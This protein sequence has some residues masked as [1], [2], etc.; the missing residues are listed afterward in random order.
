MAPRRI[1]ILAFPGLQSLDL[2]GPAEVFATADRLAGG[3]EYR[4]EIVGPSDGPLTTSSGI[5][6]V[7]HRSIARE[8]GPLDTLVVAGGLGM[9]RGLEYEPLIAWIRRAAGRAR[10]VA[11]VCNGSFLLARAGLLDGRRATTHWAWCDEL[12][13]RHPEIAV[14]DEP[15]FV[16][17]GSIYTSAGVTAGIDLSL[18]LVEED[19]GSEAAL[20][21]ARW[22]VLFLKRPGN[23]AQFS[24]QLAGQAA[25][26]PTL[27]DLQ[28]W[29]ADHLD[30]DLSVPALAERAC[31]SP[32][33]FA[34]VFQ[35]EVGLTPGA[36]VEA[37]RLER[38]RVA[39]E[40]TDAAV[41]EVARTCGFGTVESL[42]RAFARR[43]GLSP[44][45]YRNHFRPRLR[46]AA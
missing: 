5:G 45:E 46:D 4:V 36:Y 12:R 27:R 28:G 11:S 3:G 10:R 41:E 25:R 22:L 43:L 29:V 1:A 15:I 9:V 8:R 34:R 26:R 35:R 17:D 6:I 23:Q 19:L 21:V 13:R 33:N 44:S 7:P 30:A 39:L 16:R 14:E 37:V 42:R 38:A 2:F 18:A 31:M 20:E 24:T 40:T 32:R